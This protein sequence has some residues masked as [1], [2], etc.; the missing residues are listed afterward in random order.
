MLC[1]QSLAA[2]DAR[3]AAAREAQLQQLKAAHD[4]AVAQAN[5]AA[6]QVLALVPACLQ[7]MRL[8]EGL[9]A[10]AEGEPSKPGVYVGWG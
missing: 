7:D 4:A 9:Q 2:A 6:A 8:L 10:A 5:A 1:R 3:V